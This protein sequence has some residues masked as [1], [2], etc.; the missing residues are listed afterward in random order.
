MELPAVAKMSASA[1]ER[2]PLRNNS[3]W[4]E[5]R[6]TI[7]QPYARPRVVVKKRNDDAAQ[8]RHIP[9]RQIMGANFNPCSIYVQNLA[10]STVYDKPACF[11]NLQQCSAR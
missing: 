3:S 9:L 6:S 10:R 5:Q 8:F 11:H 4:L 7:P 2:R 1:A